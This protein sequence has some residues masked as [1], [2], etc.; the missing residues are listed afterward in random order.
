MVIILYE[1][2]SFLYIDNQKDETLLLLHGWGCDYSYM[3][4]FTKTIKFAN[5]LLVDLPGFGKNE[6]LTKPLCLEDYSNC[7]LVF[8]KRKNFS[9]KYIV[10]HSFGGKLSVLVASKLKIKALFLLAPSIFHKTRS[11]KYY[12]CVFIY[13]TLK[14]LRFPHSI[15]NK[16]GSKD[17]R[18]LSP[19]MK[20]TMSLIINKDISS[21]LSK[22]NVPTIVFFGDKD[23]IT[24]IYLYKKIKK[25][26]ND[27]T[28]IKI[29][30]NHFAYL[31]NIIFISN[32]IEKVLKIK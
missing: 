30:G 15:L 13:K 16:F 18:S 25:N 17:Y 26:T 7:L 4:P 14:K 24:P 3:L 5:L 12:L 10:G 19:V 9:P 2:N 6:Q 29:K 28:L 27:S 23:K 31:S 1:I 11:L 22:L 20:K 21:E 8:L 32:I